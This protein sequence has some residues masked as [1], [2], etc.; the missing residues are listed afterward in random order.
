MTTSNPWDQLEHEPDPAYHY[1]QTFLNL[2]ERPRRL[3]IISDLFGLSYKTIQNY[4]IAYNWLERVR[5]YDEVMFTQENMSKREVIKALQ[6]EVSRDG[7]D[8][9]RQMREVWRLALEKLQE[10]IDGRETVDPDLLATLSGLA[11]SRDRINRLG[12]SV[13]Q[14][15][16]TYRHMPD[17][18]DEPKPTGPMYLH[19]DNG[20][21]MLEA[22]IEED[23]STPIP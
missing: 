7:L 18:A 15:P 9:Y 13:A 11:L 2:V 23:S 6:S 21:M 4:S 5:L 1:F 12:R 19:P 22:S 14:M 10:T 16:T 17:S 3:R 20:P 8:D